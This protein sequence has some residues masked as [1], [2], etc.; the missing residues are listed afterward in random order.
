MK[1]LAIL[2]ALAAGCERRAEGPMAA[3][4]PAA[5][6]KL[7]EDAEACGNRYEC[8]PLQELEDLA[9]RPREVRVLEAAFDLMVDPKLASHERLFKMASTTARAWCAARTAHGQKL[10]I[11]DEVALK[12]QVTRLLAAPDKVIVG[13]S[14][15]EY[16]AD[17]RQIFEAEAIDPARDADAV[18]SAIR[19]LR[20]REPDL[21]TVTRWLAATDERVAVTGASLLDMIDH[22]HVVQ[23]DEVA[24]LL[25]FARRPDSPAAA[26]R[27]V[28][29][30]A[31]DHDDPAFAPVVQAFTAHNDAQVRQLVTRTAR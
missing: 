23:A 9:A 2:L 6:R 25:E 10:S 18:A 8:P 7:F 16:L 21:K 15:V 22:D 14:F 11:D 27:Q 30:H 24:M 28:A 5:L 13:H 19:G 20:T 4:N 1:R 29:Q 17:A 12:K 26:A 31:I 3:D